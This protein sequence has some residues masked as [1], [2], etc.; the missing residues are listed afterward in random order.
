VSRLGVTSI[1]VDTSTGVDLRALQKGL[2]A[3]AEARDTA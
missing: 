3:F 2:K 1:L